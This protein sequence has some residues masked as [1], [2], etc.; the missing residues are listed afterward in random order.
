MPASAAGRAAPQDADVAADRLAERLLLAGTE[1]PSQPRVNA[2]VG[3]I[4]RLHVG[5]T[6]E[7]FVQP[8]A[9]L[10]R[11]ALV[12]GLVGQLAKL[13]GERFR[14][15][16]QLV[17]HGFSSARIVRSTQSNNVARHALQQ[18][19][20]GLGRDLLLLGERLDGLQAFVELTHEGPLSF[21]QFFQTV[22]QRL[23][24]PLQQRL[25]GQ[26]PVG[27]LFDH[28]GGQVDRPGLAAAVVAADQVPRDAADPGKELPRRI[29]RLAAP[30]GGQTGLLQQLF[31]VGPVGHQ[32]GDEPVEP[33][34]AG[35][36]LL[37][38]AVLRGVFHE[39]PVLVRVVGRQLAPS[40]VAHPGVNAAAQG[41]AASLRVKTPDLEGRPTLP[42]PS[43]IATYAGNL[44]TQSYPAVKSR[45]AGS[46]VGQIANLPLHLGRSANLPHGAKPAGCGKSLSNSDYTGQLGND[47]L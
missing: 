6:A 46:V 10:F 9:F 1:L 38:E 3:Q 19:V 21:R 37:D 33:A 7:Q 44:D 22:A 32:R 41:L 11:D 20:G 43:P 27:E 26:L 34:V 25:V 29:E 2:H 47:G 16:R 23:L 40:A 8:Q 42:V 45:P 12:A 15:G 36:Q 31:G 4:V 28:V 24:P 5:P 13:G 35:H 18:L 14:Q 30:P 39:Y 17:Q